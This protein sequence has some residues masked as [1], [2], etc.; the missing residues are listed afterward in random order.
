[1]TLTCDY[2][3]C[4]IT[5]WYYKYKDKVFCETKNSECIKCYLLDNIDELEEDYL[6]TERY[7]VE[8]EL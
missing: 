7:T 1:M 8:E 4:E 5:G 3:G 2:C 6:A